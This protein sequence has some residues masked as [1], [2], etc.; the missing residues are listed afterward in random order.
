MR[1]L[2]AAVLIAVGLLGVHGDTRADD[3]GDD[4]RRAGVV[5]RLGSTRV[6]TVGEL[7]DRLAN[8]PPFQRATFGKDAATVKRA[9]L[10]QVLVPEVL[11]SLG[12]EAA[13]LGD[14]LPTSYALERVR[15]QSVVRAI[16]ARLGP[17]S[18][19]SMQDVQAY[20]D[21]NR[22]R[23]DTP[24]R[25][26][27]WRVLCKTRDEAQAVLDAAKKDPTSKGFGDLARDHSIDKG[28][29]LR[30]GNLGFITPDGTSN[31]PGLRVDPALVKAVQGVRDGELVPAPVPEGENWAVVWRKGTI[32]ATKRPV[33]QVAAQIRD[34][35]WKARVK[36]ETDKLT[37]SLRASKLRD[38]DEAPLALLGTTPVVDAAPPGAAG[39][40]SATAS[41]SRTPR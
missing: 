10:E 17:E 11:E 19:I 6:I 9:F 33:D 4:A 26:Q 28:S 15:S 8:V 37:A 16:R 40:P 35:L 41:P 7:E 3:A 21:A 34:T 24:E 29:N 18:S 12:A 30:G 14:Q 1:R 23:Y 5:V 39:S 22:S 25:Y 20:Y 31:E 38:F 2:V 32:V 36:D 13:K 27:I